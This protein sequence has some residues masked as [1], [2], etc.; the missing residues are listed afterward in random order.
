MRDVVFSAERIGERVDGGAAGGAEGDTR[1]VG[2][3]EEGA[4]QRQARLPTPLRYLQIVL[5]DY[6]GGPVRE[7]PGEIGGLRR[8]RGLH[9][10]NE[11]VYRARGEYLEGQV[12]QQLRDEHRL[13]GEEG[14]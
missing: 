5:Y 13:V 6:L 4:E 9:G 14:V 10:V 8:E 7:Q 11:R 3:G 12:A 1:V 2:G